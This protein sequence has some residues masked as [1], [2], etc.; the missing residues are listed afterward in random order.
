[1]Y[2]VA[3]MNEEYLRST[4]I[5][6]LTEDEMNLLMCLISRQGYGRYRGAR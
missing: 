2:N 5:A 3:K 6:D 1:M 4:P